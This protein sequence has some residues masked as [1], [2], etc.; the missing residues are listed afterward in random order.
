ME[1]SQNEQEHKKK[2]SGWIII[3]LILLVF[4]VFCCLVGSVFCWGSMRLPDLIDWMYENAEDLGL[5]EEELDQLFQ[6]FEM[7]EFE[8]S[9]PDVFEQESE[10]FGEFSGCQNL[11]GSLEMELMV[12]PAEVVGLDPVVI[13]QI[14]FS[15]DEDGIV[16]GSGSLQYQDVLEKEWGT[17]TV[18]FE[19]DAF[20]TG[21]CLDSGDGGELNLTLEFTGEQMV[22][23]DLGG[24]VQ[25]Y[26]WSGTRE[27]DLSFPVQEGAREEGEGWAFVLQLN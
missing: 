6:D 23:V 19:G 4:L 3:L 12:G 8:E 25:E 13:G 10:P 24:A 15:V 17:Y 11:G 5:D 14:P 1:S 26:P 9:E 7:D 16:A 22:E 20:L 21:V 2:R 18:F 27:L